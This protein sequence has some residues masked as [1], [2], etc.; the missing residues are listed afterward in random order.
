MSR[1]CGSRLFIVRG[2]RWRKKDSALR[3][4]RFL[5]CVWL[6]ATSAAFAQTGD[7]AKAILH[8][9]VAFASDEDVSLRHQLPRAYTANCDAQLGQQIMKGYPEIQEGKAAQVEVVENEVR[10]AA[11]TD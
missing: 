8:L 5:V 9:R 7:S 4:S 2:T 3:L 6:I 11:P 1:Y 10:V